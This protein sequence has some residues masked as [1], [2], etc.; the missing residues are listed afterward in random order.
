MNIKKSL[1]A[2]TIAH[3]GVLFAH[4]QQAMNGVIK[5]FLIG[6]SIATAEAAA[7][8]IYQKQYFHEGSISKNKF[9]KIGLNSIHISA[10]EEYMAKANYNAEI[11]TD[12]FKTS[13]NLISNSKKIGIENIHPSYEAYMA[14][15]NRGGK[16]SKEVF[17]TSQNL[18]NNSKKYSHFMSKYPIHAFR[19]ALCRNWLVVFSVT[20]KYM[21][22]IHKNRK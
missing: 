22:D 13:Q 1:I 6:G 10:Y 18:I 14:E 2:L 4:D 3:A 20:G 9:K 19:N 21:Y 16:I 17:E 15:A 12:V 7:E 5:N 11:P 8:Y